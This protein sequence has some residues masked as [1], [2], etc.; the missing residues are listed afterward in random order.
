MPK[1]L[2]SRLFSRRFAGGGPACPAPG[3]WHIIKKRGGRILAVFEN[4]GY[5]PALFEKAAGRRGGRANLKNQ[6]RR[7][8]GRMESFNMRQKQ[9][10]QNKTGKLKAGMI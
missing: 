6:Q 3:A 10:R 2:F 8:A 9:M 4:P 7:A 5:M 1:A